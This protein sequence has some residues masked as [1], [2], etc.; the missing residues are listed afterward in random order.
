VKADRPGIEPATCKLQVQRCHH[1]TTWMKI[2]R[3]KILELLTCNED[4]VLD[5][6][7]RVTSFRCTWPANGVAALSSRSWRT[8]E[9]RSTALLRCVLI[10]QTTNTNRIKGRLHYARIC[11]APHAEIEHVS[12]YTEFFTQ[13]SATARK[14]PQAFVLLRHRRP[15]SQPRCMFRSRDVN[16]H[17]TQ[18]KTSFPELY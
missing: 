10:S 14:T 7:F 9:R 18:Y 3:R 1:A 8:T 12:I 4:V 16:L 6:Y 17:I 15:T 5:V 11:N 2:I 13:R